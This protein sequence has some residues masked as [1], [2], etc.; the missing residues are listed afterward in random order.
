LIKFLGLIGTFAILASTAVLSCT[1]PETDVQMT[2]RPVSV[3]T[4]NAQGEISKDI[5]ALFDKSNVQIKYGSSFTPVIT[6]DEAIAIAKKRLHD[7]FNWDTDKLE[8][9]ATVALY[10][11]H[12]YQTD[13]KA[14]RTVY[15][16]PSWIV[17]VKDVPYVQSGG[18]P[19]LPGEK[20]TPPAPVKFQY[21]LAIDAMTGEALYGEITSMPGYR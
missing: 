9:D 19:P 14:A 15:D 17:V 16:I 1:S 18:P 3:S 12:A 4:P 11:G 21:N 8:A 7:G 5:G 10:S 20:Y 2:Q 13:S 6:R